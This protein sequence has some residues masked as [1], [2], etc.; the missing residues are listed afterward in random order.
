[1]IFAQIPLLSLQIFLPL[2]GVG[3]IMM[4]PR[5]DDHQACNS[6]HVALII[7]LMTFA[8]SIINLIKFD[9]HQVGFQLIEKH[10]WHLGFNS[11][12]YV[13]V[14]GLSLSLIVLTT[15]LM[16]LIIL[17]TWQSVKMRIRHYMILFLILE[18]MIMGAFCALDFILFYLFFEGV[19]IPMFFIIGIW[20]GDNRIYATL[21]FFL[22][23]FL[24]SI[25]MLVAIL[26]IY[27]HTQ[28]M[29][30]VH[31]APLNL[32]P[33]T[34]CLLWLA[35]FASF[36]VKVPMWPFHTWLP[37]AHV[38]APTAGSVILAGVLLKLGGYGFLR[39]SLPLLPHASEYFAPLM[40][41]LS[42]IAVIYASLVAMVQTDIKKLIAYSS[43]A[44]MGFVTLG[45][46]SFSTLGLQGSMFQM[47]SHGVISSGLFLSVG[48]IYD[49]MHTR[50]IAAYG[51]LAE[52]MPN[53]AT[54]FMILTLAGLGLP[55]TSGFVGEILVLIAA[56]EIHGFVAMLM[57]LGVILAAGYM[58]WLYRR[59]AL[60]KLVKPSLMKISDLTLIERGIFTMLIIVIIAA[61]IMP[62]SI[63]NLTQQALPNISPDY[64][65]EQV[66]ITASPQEQE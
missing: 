12:Y 54:N 25:L 66:V 11:H 40:V 43:I 29:D 56:F 57:G 19:L 24:G 8:V 4:M 3:F 17:S 41:A 59:V 39:F 47:L 14:D 13:G 37:D 50:Q 48:V 38:E 51:G 7:T 22:Y 46:F 20:G 60:G 53:Y 1:M 42:I 10:H 33:M 35:F 55:G 30:I 64:S 62:Q 31:D 44:H 15:F 32:S 2:I 18:T 26:V 23:T 21:K 52:R 45:A 63:L 36:A 49:R 58:L 61:G 9:V 34:Q 28:T 5:V 16:P 27:S 65:S 6:R